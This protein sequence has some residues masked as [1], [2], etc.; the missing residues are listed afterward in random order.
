M[1]ANILNVDLSYKQSLAWEYLENDPAIEELFYG[2][3]AGGGKAQPL[4]AKVLTPFGFRLMRDIGPGSIIMHPS[5]A[6][7]RVIAEHPQG[8]KP[9]YEITFSDGAKTRCCKDHLWLYWQAREKSKLEKKSGIKGRIATTEMIIDRV[10]K[11]D[12]LII[13]LCAPIN[14][15]VTSKYKRPIDKICPYVVGVLIGDGHIKKG[16]SFTSNDPEII[17]NV[18]KG[19][20]PE[21]SVRKGSGKFAY[22]IFSGAKNEKGY[23]V[24]RLK[25]IVADM[26]LIGTVSANKFIPTAYFTASLEKR[27]S[28]LQGLM[29][30]DGTVDKDG[31]VSYCTISH[32]LATGIQELLRSVGMK[33][34]IS[35]KENNHAGAYIIYIQGANKQNL[36]RLSRKKERCIDFNGGF[37]EAGRRIV[38]VE[39][40]GRQE[41]KCITV[42]APDGLYVT[43]DYIVTH[44]SRL[45]CDWQIYRRLMYPGTRGLIGRKQFTDL[46]TTTWKTFQERW[47]EVWKFNEMGVTWRK[48]G[49]NEIFWSNG[50][51]T[52]LKA[53]SYQPS[54]PNAHNFGSLEL[55][56]VFIDE[57]PEVEQHIV[58]IVNSRI[59]YKLD[60]VPHG[61]PKMLITGNP[62]PGWTKARYI[63]DDKGNPVVLRDYQAV[64]RSLL[65]DNPDPV[66]REAYRKQLEKLPLFERQRLLYGDYDAISRTGNEA[67][68]SFNQDF[69]VRKLQYDPA[70]PVM[71]LTF[72]Q[73]VVPY[74]T[75]LVAQCVYE[76][77]ESG[78][79]LKIKILKEYCLK[80]PRS[81]TQSLC[82]AFLIDWPTVQGIYIYGDASGNKRDTRA[83]KSDYEIAA[84]VL[85][86]KISSK[87][88]RV[89]K[90]NPEIRKRVLFLCAIFE[91]KIPGVEIEVD[92]DC[93]NLIQDLQHVK[94]DANGG[95]LK[96]KVTVNGVNYEKYG[97]TSDALEYLVTTVLQ[98]VFKNFEKLLQ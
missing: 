36:F 87:S 49:E 76:Q 41:A 53:L 37:S 32:K 62:D 5:G 35:R 24:N 8:V 34:T 59:R 78:Q 15:S 23:P 77:R 16:L 63:K 7:C 6:N 60:K 61:I 71:H 46:M 90:S 1:G 13:P 89:Q 43:D 12:H 84:N 85:R 4:D 42:E 14:F 64:V 39:Y 68:Y 94:T 58:D 10:D 19:L 92:A 54:N 81:T 96:E 51:E 75:L 86:S 93:Y 72:D 79:V 20:P 33:A 45:G 88:M 47:E 22:S 69:H 28:L 17:E 21:F 50:S 66:F 27:C 74:I 57:S 91:G 40:V 73:N 83:A 25:D 2:G 26:G 11:G 31:R 56:D 80:H 95:K 48:G 67:Y 29:D 65:R 44:N 30:T 38:S 97:H 82:E 52:I 55:T 9:I 18:S 98:S 70:I 3:S